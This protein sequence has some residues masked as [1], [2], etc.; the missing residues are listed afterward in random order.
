MCVLYIGPE[1]EDIE[2]EG[3]SD[4]LELS[5]S[6]PLLEDAEINTQES[7]KEQGQ[8]GEGQEEEVVRLRMDEKAHFKGKVNTQPKMERIW[9]YE[10][11]R[12][13]EYVYMHTHTRVCVVHVHLS[14]TSVY[15]L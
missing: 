7:Q 6:E 10:I 8:Q 13:N 15:S 3:V 2:S 12:V 9:R 1:Q 14:C 11:P 5:L 4:D